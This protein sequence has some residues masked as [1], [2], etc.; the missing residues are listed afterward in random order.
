MSGEMISLTLHLSYSRGVT[1]KNTNTE[2]SRVPWAVVLI[3]V[4]DLTTR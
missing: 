2:L 1:L 4:M 3:S